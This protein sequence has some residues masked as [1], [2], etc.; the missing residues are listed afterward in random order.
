M[1][2]VPGSKVKTRFSD[3][4]SFGSVYRDS[5]KRYDMNRRSQLQGGE[6]GFCRKSLMQTGSS[7]TL[8]GWTSGKTTYIPLWDRMEG[9]WLWAQEAQITSQ[10]EKNE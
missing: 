9:A 10:K 1:A 3:P 6:T 2:A 5:Y 8:I 7:E 4:D